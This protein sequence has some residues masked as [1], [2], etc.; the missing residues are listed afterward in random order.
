MPKK[1]FLVVILFFA[2]LYSEA[3]LAQ[4]SVG[5]KAGDWVEYKVST[6][7]A[8]EEGHDVVWARMEVL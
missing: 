1:L 7:G 8:A 3:V 2:L 6:T 5:V 4:V